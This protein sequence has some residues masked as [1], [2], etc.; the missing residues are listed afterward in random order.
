MGPKS[1][2]HIWRQGWIL[3]IKINILTVNNLNL[4]PVKGLRGVSVPSSKLTERGFEHDRRWMLIDSDNYFLSQRTHKELATYSSSLD[5][6]TGTIIIEKGGSSL[7]ISETEVS[8]TRIEV[9]VFE[10]RFLAH[11]AKPCINKWWSEQLD[12]HVRMVY[13]S[14]DDIRIKSYN[15]ASSSTEVSFADGYPYLLLGTASVK[16]LNDKLEAEVRIDRFRANIIVETQTP[17]IEDTWGNLKIGSEY[18]NAVKKCARCSVI[19]IDQRSGSFSKEPLATLNSYRKE[20]K[21]VN[22]GLNL[23]SISEGTISLG[24]RVLPC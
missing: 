23:V 6:K 20:G 21:K 7:H 11:L 15:D 19:N 12:E 22:F 16:K 9:G 4:Y 10:H 5:Q 18:M 3:T 14:E 17:H 24:D 1:I 13:M 2:R 8:D